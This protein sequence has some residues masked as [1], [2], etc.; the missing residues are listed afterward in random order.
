MAYTSRKIE[1]LAPDMRRKVL[2]AQRCWAAAGLDVLVTCTFRDNDAQAFLY[3]S[4]RTAKGPILTCAKPGQSLHNIVG[5]CDPTTQ[6]PVPA[7]RAI[8][9]VP[10]VHGK[11]SWGVA[12]ESLKLWRRVGEIGEACGLEWAGR[13][14]GGL[15]ELPHF[16]I[17]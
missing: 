9:V 3:A 10:M 4:G 17:K 11:C 6:K 15:R 5:P 8:D 12:G 16:Q 1:D 14:S 7:S 13:W 2:E